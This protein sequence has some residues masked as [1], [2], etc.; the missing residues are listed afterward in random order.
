MT[1]TM[2]LDCSTLL[3]Q[4]W[5]DLSVG[6]TQNADVE[7]SEIRTFSRYPSKYSL[8]PARKSIKSLHVEL[9]KTSIGSFGTLEIPPYD[10]L[11]TP[12]VVPEPASARPA[13]GRQSAPTHGD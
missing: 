13:A 7:F 1:Q 9:M 8:R 12:F 6:S 10:N 2:A 4:I 11:T 5:I 3:R